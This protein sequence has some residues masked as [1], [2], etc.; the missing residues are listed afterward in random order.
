MQSGSPI[1]I[2]LT[3]ASGYLGGRLLQCLEAAEYRL[4]CLPRRPEVLAGRIAPS[5]VGSKWDVVIP[6][7]TK[8]DT[9]GY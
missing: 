7:G 9:N 4:R 1:A 2:L 6:D 8:I 5:P 3:G